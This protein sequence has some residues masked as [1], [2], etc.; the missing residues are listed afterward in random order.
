MA[1]HIRERSQS[2]KRSNRP[3]QALKP[4]PFEIQFELQRKWNPSQAINSLIQTCPRPN[5]E[6]G[7]TLRHICSSCAI[8]S[9]SFTKTLSR[10]RDRQ[11]D[12]QK[13]WINSVQRNSLTLLCKKN[14]WNSEFVRH[15]AISARNT[16]SRVISLAMALNCTKWIH[17]RTREKTPGSSTTS[18]W[19]QPWNIQ[20]LHIWNQVNDLGEIALR[21][22]MCVWTTF[23]SVQLGVVNLER[24]TASGT[25]S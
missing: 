19:L 11:E 15:Q 9:N 16:T 3:S 4:L 14:I 6:A 18:D 20:N 5:S 21:P 25:I 24:I 17:L 2:L 10:I 13:L 1:N 8:R 7:R 22:G 12:S 23:Q